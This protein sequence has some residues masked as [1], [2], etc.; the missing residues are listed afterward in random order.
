MTACQALHDRN[1]RA[2]DIKN[3]SVAD[4]MDTGSPMPPPLDQVTICSNDDD[5]ATSFSS[6]SDNELFPETLTTQTTETTGTARSIF[7]QYWAKNGGG[8]L[9][10]MTCAARPPP[11]TIVFVQSSSR[12]IADQRFESH[13]TKPK[14]EAPHQQQQHHH[15]QRRSIFR[16]NCV[17]QS[18]SPSVPAQGVASETAAL[19]RNASTSHSKMEKVSKRSCLLQCRYSGTSISRDSASFSLCDSDHSER[20]SE[21]SV[22]FSPRVQVLVYQQPLERYA[23][24][25]WSKYFAF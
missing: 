17:S 18:L 12:A 22:N 20:S 8:D 15:Q 19:L 9:C 5:S 7:K 14:K 2:T 16:R 3:S 1:T 11:R 10:F 23:T 13:E 21:R 25:G 24:E 6:L 4:E